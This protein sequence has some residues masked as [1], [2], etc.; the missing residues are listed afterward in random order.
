[1]I[2]ALTLRITTSAM[3]WYASLVS[4]IGIVLLVLLRDT[5]KIKITYSMNRKL[6]YELEDPFI[7]YTIIKVSNVGRRPITIHQIGAKHLQDTGVIYGN[8]TPPLPC[9]LTEGKYLVAKVAQGYLDFEKIRCFFVTDA[10]GREF[11]F[12][13][14][15]WV[16]RGYWTMRRYCLNLPR[17]RKS[18]FR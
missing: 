1:M 5:V 18:V 10:A 7:L 3:A 12:P 11:T 2:P 8:T 15:G 14:A 16:R 9:E 13:Y 6:P 17:V 4:T